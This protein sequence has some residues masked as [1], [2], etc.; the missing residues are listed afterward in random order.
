MQAREGQIAECIGPA[1]LSGDDV[2]H[3]EPQE[4]VCG[5]E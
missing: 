3:L 1:V 2:F 4:N 5:G